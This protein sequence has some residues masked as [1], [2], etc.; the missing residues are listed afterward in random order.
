MSTSQKKHPIILKSK[1]IT[2]KISTCN[3]LFVNKLC[4][5]KKK[6]FV[7]RFFYIILDVITKYAFR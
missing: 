2:K 6:L 1:F 3:Y 5:V 7:N 4:V